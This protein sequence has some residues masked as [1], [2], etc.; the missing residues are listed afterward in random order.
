M[1]YEIGS[2]IRDLR[3][4]R[5]YSQEELCYGICSTGNLSKIENGVRMPNRK[6]I[7]AVMQRLGSE[8][9]FL[10]FSSREEMHQERLCKK[11]VRKLSDMDFEG[12]EEIVREFEATITEEDILNSQYC[13]FTR[14]MINQAEGAPREQVIRELEETLHMTKPRTPDEAYKLE[15][16]LT[17]N[18]IVILINIANNY[19]GY[20]NKRAIE[21]LSGL[22]QYM[23]THI[24]D[25]Q[26]R[27][28]KYQVVVFNLGDILIDEKRYDEAIELCDLGIE[29]CKINNRLRLF[30]YFLANK[31]F[32]L[33]G[34][35]EEEQA[36]IQFKK[37]Y[38]MWEAMENEKACARLV[39]YLKENWNFTHLL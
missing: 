31:G 27:I 8:N 14:V 28:K 21:I 34:K 23:D 33:L 37:A 1:V 25:R 38:H 26:E 32:A 36:Q 4:E 19:A 15:G 18:E 17:Y 22:K 24:L 2:F 13:R 3:L 20:D 5:G 10:Q 7:E 16:L 6:T 29:D 9:V 30:P 39:Q 11:I 12:L 35:G